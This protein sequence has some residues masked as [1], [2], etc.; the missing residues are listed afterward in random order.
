[1]CVVSFFWMNATLAKAVAADPSVV[2]P[3]VR[4]L[5]SGL[6]GLARLAPGAEDGSVV[7]EW[8]AMT[9]FS[10]FFVPH[11]YFSTQDK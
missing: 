10:Q 4:D 1:M 7:D 8:K 6:A 2:Y 9:W 5:L 11:W 3:A